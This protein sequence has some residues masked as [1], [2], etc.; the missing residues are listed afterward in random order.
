MLKTKTTV[1]YKNTIKAYNQKYRIIANK[2]GT[3]SGKTFATLQL[4]LTIMIN[5]PG[6]LIISVVSHSFPH[7]Y[8][9]AI[10]DW[11]NII[12]TVDGL[13]VES[14]RTKNPH[15]YKIGKSL[16]EFIGFDKPGKAL[17]AARDILFINE[18]N[19]M[20]FSVCH[21]LMQRTTRCI[22]LDWNP[23]EQYWFQT[24]GIIDRDDCIVIN[25]TFLDNIQN[26]TSGQLSDLREAKKK[27]DAEVE[28]GTK[29]YWYNWWRVYGLG[30]DGKLEGVIFTNW[31]EFEILPSD[32]DYYRIF[33]VDFG[34]VDPTTL[35]EIYFDRS[36]RRAY[37]YEHKYEPFTKEFRNVDLINLINDVNANNDEVVCD[38]ARPDLISEMQ[39]AG[40]AAMR[41]KKGANSRVIHRELMQQFTWY[42]HKKSKNAIRE[43][44][45]H[46]WV[47]GKDGEA[48]KKPEDANDHII[49]AV[50]YGT[51]YYYRS[52]IGDYYNEENQN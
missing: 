47:I 31:H 2:G 26:L 7:L 15:I 9:G 20:P 23:S 3:R 16:L 1:V 33:V 25:S 35:S 18:A 46:K 22:F 34:S 48:T 29:G 43:F 24:Q 17:G 52:F 41:A 13:S 10:R 36:E 14:V 30:L 51:E 8:G 27:H 49:D 42:L 19:K 11:E 28:A 45:T 5:S 39:I 50:G 40:I 12:E 38:S 6:K 4:L 37:L 44:E 32:I 21:Q